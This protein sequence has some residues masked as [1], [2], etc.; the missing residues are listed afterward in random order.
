MK[1]KVLSDALKVT[2][3]A[4]AAV[5]EFL[6]PISKYIRCNVFQYQYRSHKYIHYL[7]L[8]HSFMR[9]KKKSLI[10]GINRTERMRQVNNNLLLMYTKRNKRS[11]GLSR[12]IYTTLSSLLD[13]E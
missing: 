12:V 3:D 2:N 7:L 9:A 10:I 6:L 5:V 1:R 13:S 8:L 4:Q 11:K